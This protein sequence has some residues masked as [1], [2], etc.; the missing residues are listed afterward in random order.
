MFQCCE[1]LGDFVHLYNGCIYIGN[2]M[3]ESGVDC[4]SM[5]RGTCGWNSS[6]AGEPNISIEGS[7]IRL[8][9]NMF[10]NMRGSGSTIVSVTSL[11]YGFNVIDS[12]QGCDANGMFSHATGFIPNVSLKYVINT[13]DMFSYASCYKLAESMTS[14]GVSNYLYDASS[15][16]E[17]F[18][19]ENNSIDDARTTSGIRA[20]FSNW[21]PEQ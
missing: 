3:I 19:N 20:M 4:T 11:G 5:F 16:F 15:M 17:G 2:A 7:Y 18:N 8:A 9:K 21:R 1:R 13:S 12:S 6:G 10:A 14:S